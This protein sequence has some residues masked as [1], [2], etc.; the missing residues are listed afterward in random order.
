MEI[1]HYSSPRVVV[2]N[3]TEEECT[4]HQVQP[5]ETVSVRDLPG[6]P[7]AT[8]PPAGAGHM[9][10]IPGPRKIPNALEQ[11]SLGATVTGAHVP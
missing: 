6:G 3:I 5:V 10:S 1:L 11:Q 4:R 2:Y 8:D 7:V 9:G